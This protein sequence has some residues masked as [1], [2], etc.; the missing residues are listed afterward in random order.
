MSC[1]WS[2]LAPTPICSND[3]HT[4]CQIAGN[5]FYLI[6]LEKTDKVMLIVETKYKRL[7]LGKG[8]EVMLVQLVFDINRFAQTSQL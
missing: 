3:Q 2:A 4:S 7:R 5:L 1:S 8:I 6:V